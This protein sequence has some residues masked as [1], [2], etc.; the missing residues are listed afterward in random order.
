VV[1]AEEVMFACAGNTQ[2]GIADTIRAK[3]I[4][5]LVVSACSP[6]THEGTF[7]RTCVKAGLNPYL[8][9]M[10][11]L[12]NHDSW[13]HKG[14]P[15]AATRKAMDMVDMGVRKAALLEPLVRLEQPI[16]QAALVIGGGI[17]GMTAAANLARQGYQTHLVEREPA[18][19]GQLRKLDRLAPSGVE[20]RQL[21]EAHQHDV[22]QA[23]VVV[24]LD[25]EVE[26]IGGHVGNYHARLS[27]GEEI[28]VGAVIL[29]TGAEP[30]K[31][32][33]FGYGTRLNV[34]TNLELEA[35]MPNPPCDRVT[36]VACV[37]ARTGELG[38]ARYCCT[39]MIHQA[40]RLRRE[41]KMVR[42]LYKDIR[43]FGRD[44]E[45]LYEEAMRAGVQFIRY[46]ANVAP[47]D[48]VQF[49]DGMVTVYDQLLGETVRFTT[50]L[51]V[52][53]VGLSPRPDTLGQQLKVAHSTDGFF[54]EKHPKLGPAEASSP[55]VYL[56]G[57]A[58]A[59]KDA[60]DSA[61]QA[62]AAAGKAGAL[63][64]RDTIGK[65]PLTAQVQAEKCTGCTLCA[66]YCPFNAI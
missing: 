20:A 54:L 7:R 10:V 5:R 46:D 33:E 17:A 32:T 57:A 9:E 60:R 43:T 36:F 52:L 19:G 12:R 45:E 15:E 34:I 59:P 64:S 11:N 8:L 4:T 61:A 51:L 41:G 26:V 35:L 62:L 16:K 18:L 48:A 27:T 25:T 47:A 29:A 39:S 28:H 3:G 65:E 31:P 38:C 23:G 55:G 66:L 53:V 13:V 56:A 24:Y 58:Q 30:Y 42:V 37:G 14:E 44:A 1:H 22:E 21:I 2:Q 49:A 50:D 63:L 6:K 40:L